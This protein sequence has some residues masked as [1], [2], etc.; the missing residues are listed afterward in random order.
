MGTLAIIWQHFQISP[1]SSPPTLIYHLLPEEY[2]VQV[3]PTAT[4]ISMEAVDCN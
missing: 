1:V 2:S 4:H 3:S